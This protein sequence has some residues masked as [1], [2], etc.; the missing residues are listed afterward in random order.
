MRRGESGRRL[1]AGAAA[2]LAATVPMTAAMQLMHRQLPPLER[3]ALPPRRIT[4]RAADKAGVKPHL[5]EPERLVLTMAAHFG[6]GTAV[7]ALFGLI[8]PR[9]PAEAALAGAGFGLLVWTASYLGLMPALGLHRPVT[10]EPPGRN[11]LMIALLALHPIRSKNLASL[12]LSRSFVRQGDS[13]CI[14]LG[15]KETKS[16][17]PDVRR[18]DCEHGGEHAHRGVGVDELGRGDREVVE[19][20]EVDRLAHGVAQQAERLVRAAA[21]P[22]GHRALVQGCGVV[23]HEGFTPEG[24]AARAIAA[25]SSAWGRPSSAPRG[26]RRV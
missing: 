14:H 25:G 12:S 3:Y 2:G 18:V 16:G 24:Q 6:Y 17:R 8:A 10:K 23:G 5:D 19:Q 11:G 15:S 4:M 13:W 9:R 26:A 1:V 20:L 7:G 21:L 22:R